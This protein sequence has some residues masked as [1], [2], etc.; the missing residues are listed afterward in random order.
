[1][2]DW[3][4]IL[5]L[6]SLNKYLKKQS[7]CMISLQDVLR[8]LNRGDFMTSLDL[9]DAYFHI[10]IHPNHRKFLRFRVA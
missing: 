6:R 7:F 1:T 9:Q 8:L 2:G 10:P 4:P 3:R 5:D